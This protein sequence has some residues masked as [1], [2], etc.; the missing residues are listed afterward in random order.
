VEVGEG[1]RRKK[2][3]PFLIKLK[4]HRLSGSSRQLEDVESILKMS[5][6][7]LDMQYL[8][9]WAEYLQCAETLR[10]LLGKK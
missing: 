8:T 3:K 2:N 6:R 1:A 10:A 5:G 9:K 7:M 4:W